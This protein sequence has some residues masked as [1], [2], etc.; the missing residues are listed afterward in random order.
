MWPNLQFCG[1]VTF[2]EEIRNGKLCFFVQWWY[3][4]NKH[5][6]KK[7]LFK[8]QV[9]DSEEA[10]INEKRH[11]IQESLFNEVSLFSSL[12]SPIVRCFRKTNM[13][14][15]FRFR[16][17]HVLGIYHYRKYFHWNFMWNGSIEGAIEVESRNK[18]YFFRNTGFLLFNDKW[19]RRFHNPEFLPTWVYLFAVL[20]TILKILDIVSVIGFVLRFFE[21]LINL[22]PIDA[23]CI[24]NCHYSRKKI[25]LSQPKPWK[26]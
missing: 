26:G 19:K 18:F 11:S 10:F 17:F 7:N 21:V 2:T 13:F 12:R 25:L 3:W 16:L 6:H 23:L 24:S 9:T 8:D 20:K 15:D 22:A 5:W 1:C 4:F 14:S